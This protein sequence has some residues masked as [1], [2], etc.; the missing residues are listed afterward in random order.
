MSDKTINKI[1]LTG[2]FIL[3]ALMALL[4][5]TSCADPAFQ[6]Y[7]ANRQAA[8]TAMPNGPDK[9]YAQE[10]LDQQV[11][12]EKHR[13]YQE[14]QNAMAAGLAGAAAGLEASQYYNRPDV[15]VYVS[16]Y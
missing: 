10:R 13:Q 3:T 9:Y 11:L 2:C 16:R 5:L 6:N 1:V 15:N 8:I 12:A 14:A 7:I 4:G